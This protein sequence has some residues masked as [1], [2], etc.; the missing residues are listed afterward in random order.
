M[1]RL[2]AHSELA[3]FLFKTTFALI[4]PASD[5]LALP[6]LDESPRQWTALAMDGGADA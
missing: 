6:T 2:A 1:R 3:Q 4:V 5:R